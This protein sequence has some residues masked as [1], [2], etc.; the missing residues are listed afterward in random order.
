[1]SPFDLDPQYGLPLWRAL[2][3][4]FRAYPPLVQANPQLELPL[5]PPR[6]AKRKT[7]RSSPRRAWLPRELERRL[8]IQPSP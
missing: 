7:R 1:M 2:V 6:A 3:R 8:P 4:Y 5:P